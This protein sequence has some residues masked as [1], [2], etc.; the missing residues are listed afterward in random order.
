MGQPWRR[1]QSFPRFQSTRPLASTISLS[2]S[3]RGRT[4]SSDR[5]SRPGGPPRRSR[6]RS[7]IRVLSRSPPLHRG[8]PSLIPPRHHH[9]GAARPLSHHETMRGTV[10]VEGTTVTAHRR[11][12]DVSAPRRGRAGALPVG[13]PTTL[14]ADTVQAHVAPQ[15]GRSLSSERS[16]P[17]PRRKRG[18]RDRRQNKSR[19]RSRGA[20]NGRGGRLAGARAGAGAA[21]G[22]RVH[23][24]ATTK[25]RATCSRFNVQGSTLITSPV[26]VIDYPVQEW[27]T[28]AHII[29]REMVFFRIH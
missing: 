1:E 19:S 22:G 21:R 13:A 20:K 15:K 9:A 5:S 2:S 27:R 11:A 26:N 10:G 3:P 17:P 6:S 23:V 28:A 24:D 29:D 16:P 8:S 25:V 4:P 14:V 18:E 7:P 12:E